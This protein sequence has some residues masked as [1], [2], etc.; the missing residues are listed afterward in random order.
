MYNFF[1]D[2]IDKKIDLESNSKAYFD[3][4]AIQ[5]ALFHILDNT[6]KYIKENTKLIISLQEAEQNIEIIFDMISRR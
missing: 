4:E 2:I 5:V 1:P 3:Y 6:M